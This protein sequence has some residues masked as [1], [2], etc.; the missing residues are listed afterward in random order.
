MTEARGMMTKINLGREATAPL[1]AF[2]ARSERTL[3]T[4]STSEGIAAAQKMTM[5]KRRES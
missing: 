5:S 2:P 1:T 4:R 3:R